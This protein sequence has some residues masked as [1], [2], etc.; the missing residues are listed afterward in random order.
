MINQ[1]I[2]MMAAA[3]LCLIMAGCNN[4]L[5]SHSDTKSRDQLKLIA[6]N[7]IG[8]AK[9]TSEFQNQNGL[10]LLAVHSETG[11]GHI[12]T[13]TLISRQVVLTAAHCLDESVNKLGLVMVYFIENFEQATAESIRNGIK[14]KIHESYLP[15]ETM[16]NKITYDIALLKLDVE[17]PI[18]TKTARLPLPDLISQPLGVG[19]KLILAGYGLTEPGIAAPDKAA[20]APDKAAG[21]PDKIAGL[22]AEQLKSID[23]MEIIFLGLNANEFIIKQDDKGAC[24]GDSGGPAFIKSG[25]GLLTQVGVGSRASP[26]CIGISV[27]TNIINYL[28]WIKENS[29]F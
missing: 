23:D 22:A 20:G 25:D 10:V 24:T 28:P 16:S 9:A 6:S 7:I 18:T 11:A 26:S 13:G 1:K 12:C 3:G 21:T 8:G 14:W 27:Y 4:N 5:D 29:A 15:S 17:A 19:D 2:K